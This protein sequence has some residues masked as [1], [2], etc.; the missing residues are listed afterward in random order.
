MY[1]SEEGSILQSTSVSQALTSDYY[2]MTCDL[3]VVP[4]FHFPC[5]G[6]YTACALEKSAF[7]ELSA[8]IA[9]FSD[10]LTV[11]NPFRQLCSSAYTEIL[12]ILPVLEHIFW[13]NGVSPTVL[14]SNGI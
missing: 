1:R 13:A 2:C 10:L 9:Y 4:S 6:K 11:Y 12:H 3:N 5:S 8:T 14:Q 7:C